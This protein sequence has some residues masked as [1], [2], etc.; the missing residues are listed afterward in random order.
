MVL[1]GM[2]GRIERLEGE[3]GVLV[4]SYVLN[5]YIYFM[6]MLCNLCPLDL[7]NE[8]PCGALLCGLGPNLCTSLY[9]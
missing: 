3:A 4:V 6:L 2:G 8:T 7:C 1:V 5:A 9:V